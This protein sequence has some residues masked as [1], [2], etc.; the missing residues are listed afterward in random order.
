M[1]SIQH[2]QQKRKEL[3]AQYDLPSLKIQRLRENA[4]YQTRTAVSFQL[5][6]EVQRAETERDWINQMI[7]RLGLY[8]EQQGKRNSQLLPL[9]HF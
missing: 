9:Q 8:W 3:Q 1:A 5:D 2:T 6:Q 4:A 7:E